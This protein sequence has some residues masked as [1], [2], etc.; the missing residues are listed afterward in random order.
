MQSY[1]SLNHTNLGQG[2]M[3][4]DR[5]HVST[6]IAIEVCKSHNDLN[7]EAIVFKELE[8]LLNGVQLLVDS[9]I[10]CGCVGSRNFVDVL[11]CLL[12][13][14]YIPHALEHV[15]LCATCEEIHYVAQSL[16]SFSIFASFKVEHVV[17]HTICE[18]I[19][20][21]TWSPSSTL[22]LMGHLLRQTNYTMQIF[23][24]GSH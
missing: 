22:T 7:F 20:Y 15:V 2:Y 6:L 10:L 9:N 12:W 11:Q 16:L 21:M 13:R 1:L 24:E 8:P 14:L 19:H 17:L 18:E 23:G 4:L 5:L 3:I